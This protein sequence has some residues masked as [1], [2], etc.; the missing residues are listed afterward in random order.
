MAFK[1]V[2]AILALVVSHSSFTK[3]SFL[4]DSCGTETDCSEDVPNSVCL[5]GLCQCAANYVQDDGNVDGCFPR[6]LIGAPC[7]IKKQCPTNGDCQIGLNNRRRCQCTSEY[8]ANE[9]N[10][11]CEEIEPLDLGAVCRDTRQ[12]NKNVTNSE[13]IM[14]GEGNLVCQCTQDDYIPD[15]QNLSCLKVA[16]KLGDSC[17]IDAQCAKIPFIQ[18]KC[19]ETGFCDCLD[20]HVA[21]AENTQCYEI[22][23]ELGATCEIEEQCQF[24]GSNCT[25]GAC[26]CIDDWIPYAPKCLEKINDINGTQCVIDDQCPAHS[27]CDDV[28]MKCSCEEDFIADREN[29][30]CLTVLN[31]IG[32]MCME[33]SQ[34]S[35]M[36]AL[37]ENSMCACP[38]TGFVENDNFCYKKIND[39]NSSKCVI[40]E[41]CPTNS[42]CDN[43]T[44][45]CRC[46]E[47]FV[48]D[49]LSL[50]CLPVVNAT[51]EE[52]SDSTQCSGINALCENS[53]CACPSTGFI[54]KDGVCYK[55]RNTLGDPC[56]VADQC[57]VPQST[58]KA[59]ICDCIEGFIG[60]ENNCYKLVDLNVGVCEVNEQ[61]P[62]NS[63]CLLT[64]KRCQCNDDSVSSGNNK[65][66][67]AAQNTLE[68]ECLE[69]AQCKIQDSQ[70]TGNKCICRSG[71]VPEENQCFPERSELGDPCEKAIQCLVQGSTC[72]NEKCSCGTDFLDKDK[73]CYKVLHLD[74]EICEIDEQCPVN[75]NCS[76]STGGLD[77]KCQ[78]TSGYV[79]SENKSTC[80]I[81]Q[82]T[83]GMQCLENSQCT[84]ENSKCLQNTCQCPPDFT[85]NPGANSC[86]KYEVLGGQCSVD[87]QCK[88]AEKSERVECRENK[89]QC[90]QG[91]LAE[92]KKNV[93]SSGPEIALAAA[94]I[95]WNFLLSLLM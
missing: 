79:S 59:E 11:A 5:E 89:C 23:Y 93:C 91:F 35:G 61:C 84:V 26:N 78:C 7:T 32:E 13:C 56:E 82:D 81:A 36:N 55:V 47:D 16:S 77:K 90:K 9:I 4:E 71:F 28:A 15:V 80:L 44:K 50:S 29:L 14:N 62:T 69:E 41:Q 85:Q 17:E 74:G 70:C 31:A 1:L 54:E 19:N 94:A 20:T 76:L 12:C 66:C 39:I 30:S 86:L 18:S 63:T 75:S 72:L 25:D 38:S 3:A 27:A 37:C 49:I 33:S 22:K 10:T 67:L 95:L 45:N 83:L 57:N 2:V 42:T 48:A 8:L 60:K 6:R 88:L 65:I 43:E 53:M 64:T 68:A 51:G 73:I 46:E 92:T 52:C 34:C 21:D 87:V 24:M 58:C 40:D